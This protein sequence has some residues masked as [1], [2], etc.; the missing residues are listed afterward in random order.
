V[1]SIKAN[2]KIPAKD[3]VILTPRVY[4][5]EKVIDKKKAVI[6]RL[7]FSSKHLNQIRNYM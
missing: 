4:V 6:C 3:G 2:N 1:T 7:S 5:N